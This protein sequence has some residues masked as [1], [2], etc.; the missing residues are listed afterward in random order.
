MLIR[1]ASLSYT[2]RVN[3][4]VGKKKLKLENGEAVKVASQ[5]RPIK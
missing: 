1:Q 5:E 3:T 2:K 4:E